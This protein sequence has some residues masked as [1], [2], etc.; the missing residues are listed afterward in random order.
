MGSLLIPEAVLTW[1]VTDLELVAILG[2]EL[3]HWKRAHTI[4]MFVVSQVSGRSSI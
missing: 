4:Q 1:Q 3:G 2:H